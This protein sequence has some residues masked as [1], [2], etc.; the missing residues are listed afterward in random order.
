MSRCRRYLLEEMILRILSWTCV[1]CLL[2]CKSVCKSWVSSISKPQFLQAHHNNSCIKIPS[3]IILTSIASPQI[4]SSVDYEHQEGYGRRSVNI[5]YSDSLQHSVCIPLLTPFEFMD[6]VGCLGDFPT[7]L[8]LS[9]NHQDTPCRYDVVFGFDGVSNEFKVLKIVYRRDNYRL[10]TAVAV[11]LYSWNAGSWREIEVG[12]EL[13]SMVCYP[14]CPIL[15]SGPVVDGI[16]YLEGRD[17][18]VTFDLHSELFRLIPF[19][20]YMQVR[21]SNV[22]DFEGSVS[23][24]VEFVPADGSLDDKEISL[25]TLETVSGESFWNKVFTFDS[26]FKLD[27]VFFS[28]GANQFVGTTKLGTVLYESCKKVTKYIALPP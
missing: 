7:I 28:L 27:W 15:K 26:G 12:V 5:F 11:H 4:K 25:W 16:L 3:I 17:V 8:F 23:V 6:F 21:K 9:P 10:V 13:P 20:S 24:L 1:P 18:I 22:F 2:R 19:P 14:L